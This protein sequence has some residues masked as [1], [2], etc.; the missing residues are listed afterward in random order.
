M[1]IMKKTEALLDAN[2]K[3]GLERRIRPQYEQIYVI[4]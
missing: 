4:L 1:G 2:K 3:V